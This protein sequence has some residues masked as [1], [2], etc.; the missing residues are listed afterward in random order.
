MKTKT[1]LIFAIILATV[2]TL[3]AAKYRVNNTGG[4]AHFSNI[5]DAIAAASPGDTLYIEGTSLTYAGFTL[6]KPLVFIGPGYFLP[7]NNMTQANPN[8]A[9][10]SS[11]S[12]HDGSDG[13][14]IQGLTISGKITV[15]DSNIV[16]TRNRF[17]TGDDMCITIL[18]N[19]TNIIISQNYIRNS[20][21]S[22]NNNPTVYFNNN[23]TGVIITNNIILNPY[24][25]GSCITM[26]AGSQAQINN[27]V[28][29]RNL[30]LVNSNVY[31]NIMISGSASFSVC[32]VQANIGNA[33]QFN[34]P[35]NQQNVD[36]NLVFQNSFPSTDGKFQLID[37]P[38]NPAKGYGLGGVDCGPFGTNSPYRLSGVPPV[39]AVYFFWGEPTGTTTGGLPTSVK[40]KSNR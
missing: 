36:M 25:N 14:V 9:T 34:L 22:W 13:T 23:V 3:Q 16:I 31:N 7:E 17:T 20:T 21:G 35:D 32:N 28:F 12:L 15:S 38:G 24:G 29:D 37:D 39:P 4:G 1:I 19:M 10:V 33:T 5:P 26:S 2:C 8:P 40:I 27:N 6:T 30:N 11:F 18:N